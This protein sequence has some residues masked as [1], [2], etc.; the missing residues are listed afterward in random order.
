MKYDDPDLRDRLAAQYALGSLDGLARRRLE[1]QM[2]IDPDL[3]AAVDV[4]QM[5]LNGLVE[6]LPP[7]EPP[8]HV[9]TAIERAIGQEPAPERSAA[10]DAKILPFARS[11]SP[12]TWRG[13]W[14]WRG[15]GLGAVAAAAILA[16]FIGVSQFGG[17]SAD[18][19]LCVLNDA[20][21]RAAFVATSDRDLRHLA[22]TQISGDRPATGKSYQLWVLPR[23]GARPRPIGLMPQMG[24][25]ALTLSSDDAGALATA[26]GVAISLEPAGGSPTGLP[27]GP[28]LFKGGV[29][30]RP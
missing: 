27:T 3:A 16:I 15:F 28:V 14:F 18:E 29:I 10:G 19:P 12:P 30:R 22:V 26:D 6:S 23:G 24:R 7:I 25:A 2:R 13:P 8:P 1:R 5:R 17:Q 21:G 4:W 9:W 20:S 11:A